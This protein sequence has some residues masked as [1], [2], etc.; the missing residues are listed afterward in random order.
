MWAT[1]TAQESRPHR[2]GAG[3]EWDFPGA[4][5]TEPNDISG[6]TIVGIRDGTSGFTYN[7]S[8]FAP[9]DVPGE[10]GPRP[11]F[12]TGVSGAT[13]VGYYQP[14]ASIQ[15]SGFVY[16]GSAFTTVAFPGQFFTQLEGV[17]GDRAFETAFTLTLNP[18]GSLEAH[19][20][21]FITSVPEPAAA[22]ILAGIAA[23]GPPARRRGSGT[24]KRCG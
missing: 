10:F 13:V 3:L 16:D 22:E 19:G 21:G 1:K 20:P 11:T 18:L 12:V 8:T 5:D 24:W 17:S 4:Y 6:G 7:G 14:N 9:L 23:L 15:R 2:C